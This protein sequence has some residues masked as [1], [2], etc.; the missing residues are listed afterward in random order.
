MDYISVTDCICL[1]Q[2]YSTWWAAKFGRVAK[3]ARI[4]VTWV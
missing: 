3:I 2:L 1:H 4:R